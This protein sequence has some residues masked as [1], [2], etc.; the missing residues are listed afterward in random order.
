M[1]WANGWQ[2]FGEEP[3]EQCLTG[4]IERGGGLIK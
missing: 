2:V 4:A 3:A 1:R